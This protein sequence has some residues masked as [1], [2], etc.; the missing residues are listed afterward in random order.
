MILD[1]R[2]KKTAAPVQSLQSRSLRCHSRLQRSDNRNLEG[3]TGRKKEG[4]SQNNETIHLL[5]R[6]PFPGLSGD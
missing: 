2:K 6:H 1:K 3:K 5:L 4:R